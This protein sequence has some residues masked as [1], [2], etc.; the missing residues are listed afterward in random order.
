MRARV[1]ISKSTRTGKKLMA[2]FAYP[3]GQ[4]KTVHFGCASCGDFIR[5]SNVSHYLG[6]GKRRAYIARHGASKSHENWND[7]TSPGALS[8]WILWEKRSLASAIASYKRRFSI[9]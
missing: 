1:V 7:P 6:D 8:R 5:W 4:K 2:V 9:S 3:G